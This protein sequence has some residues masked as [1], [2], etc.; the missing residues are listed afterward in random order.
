VRHCYTLRPRVLC[1]L[2]AVLTL[3]AGGV[4]A[5]VRVTALVCGSY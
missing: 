5:C 1:I 4:C 3:L 2:F